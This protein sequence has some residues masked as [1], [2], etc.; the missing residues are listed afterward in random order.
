MIEQNKLELGPILNALD[1]ADFKFYSK[2]SEEH[3]KQYSPY[4]LL[5]LMSSLTDQNKMVAYA[6]LAAN[7][8]VNIGFW[9]YS[10][11]PELLHLLLCLTGIKGKQ[12]RPWISTKKSKK[13]GIV[14]SWLLEQYPMVNDDE[15][16]IIKSSYDLASWTK[17][18]KSSGISDKEV[19]ELVSAWKKQTE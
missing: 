2:L 15:L 11:H 3:K 18:V 8:L 16:D 1:K 4:I 17:L 5:H 12:Y 10:N 14:D 13:S 7:D 6:V 19:K 9:N